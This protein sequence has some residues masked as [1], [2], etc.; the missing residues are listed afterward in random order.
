MPDG[1]LFGFYTDWYG[2][3]VDGHSPNPPPAWETYHIRELIPWIDSHYPTVADRSGRAIAGLSMGGFGAM[4]YAAKHPD[5]FAAA[6]SFSGAVD[7]DYNYPY[8][9]EILTDFSSAFTDGPP[10]HCIWGDAYTQDLHWRAA[11]A[12]YIAGN[13][14]GVSL[15]LACGNGK[16]GPLDNPNSP[17]L[18][19]QE[20][21]EEFVW[22]MNEAMDAVLNATGIAHVDDFYGN[23]T[24]AWPYW[25][26]DL[27]HFLPQMNGAFKAVS[28]R[29]APPSFDY[30]SAANQFFVWG[31]RFAS[32][33]AV[34]E[35]TYLSDVSRGGFEVSGSGLV[36]VVT[37]PLYR[38]GAPA[39]VT[40]GTTSGTVVA[41][42]LGRLAFDVNLGPAHTLQQ[43]DF[44]GNAD[45]SWAHVTVTIATPAMTTAAPGGGGSQV[46]A[47][48][49]LPNTMAGADGGAAVRLLAVVALLLGL[50]SLVA[51]ALRRTSTRLRRATGS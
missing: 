51:R 41:D 34:P 4:T 33:R 44:S 14:R 48:S 5:L 28:L 23:G 32:H 38:P 37:A 6:G 9:N 45:A 47:A 43:T 19:A 2:S 36:S 29:T 11:D 13:L 39:K 35:F 12:T 49:V 21:V 10:D 1:G 16:A 20:S 22:P 18:Y 50:G 8:A 30:W 42:R 3:D 15:Y 31:W 46:A 40:I 26:R 24:H 25:L 27:T 17:A 7:T